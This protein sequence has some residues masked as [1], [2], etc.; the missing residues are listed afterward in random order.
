M[1]VSWRHTLIGTGV[2]ALAA[3]SLAAVANAQCGTCR[4]PSPPPPPPPHNSCCQTPKNVVVNVPGVNVAAANVRVGASST[5]YAAASAS[6]TTAAGIVVSSGASGG[7][8]AFGGGGGGYYSNSGVAQSSISNLTLDGGY[9]TKTV[10]EEVAMTENYCIDKIIEDIQMRPVQAMCIDDKGTPHPASRTDDSRD[11][12]SNF[13]G[14]LYRCIAGTHMQVTMG[15][16]ENGAATFAS[17]ETFE[18]AKGEALWH[19]PGG[20]LS[21]RPQAPERNCNERSLLRK[22]GPGVKMVEVSAKKTYCEPATRTNV[23][24]VAK[25][26]K[27]PRAIAAGDL[28]LDGGVGQG[29]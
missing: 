5:A 9:E 21:C 12:R 3:V 26:V 18:C 6:A 22:Y 19:A 27:V 17:G 29:Y 14:E 23:Q 7:G 4:P 25:Q 1:T 20:N 8:Y 15:K 13:K 16:V 10:E 28:A 11:V 24:K 2:A